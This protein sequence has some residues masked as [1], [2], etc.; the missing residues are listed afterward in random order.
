VIALPGRAHVLRPAAL[1]ERLQHR[2]DRRRALRRQVPA[3]PPGPVQRGVQ[4]QGPVREPAAGR[5]VL[6]VGLPGPPGL[7]GG[8]GEELQVVEVRPAA[9][10]SSRIR[11]ASCCRGG[12][13]R[14]GPFEIMGLIC[15]GIPG[16]DRAIIRRGPVT[17]SE[18]VST[19]RPCD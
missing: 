3:D 17:A 8:L 16:T 7:V 6:G 10:A 15:L 12:E 4:A 14:P 11:S 9:A 19:E 2:G 1:A 5:V 13:S 18:E